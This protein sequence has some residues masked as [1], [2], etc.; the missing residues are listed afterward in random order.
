MDAVNLQGI[1]PNFPA[2]GVVP[3]LHASTFSAPR[4]AMEDLLPF[5]EL[6]QL[7]NYGDEDIIL[8]GMEY[9]DD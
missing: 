1:W 4:E 8:L 5:L 7:V 6:R 2:Q 3:A 9:L